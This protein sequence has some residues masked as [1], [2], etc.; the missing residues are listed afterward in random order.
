ML[1]KN[2]FHSYSIQ[3]IQSGLKKKKKVRLKEVDA[4]F[5]QLNM[6]R[7]SKSKQEE[8]F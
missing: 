8:K 2:V 7:G 6:G 5:I 1:Y 3:A 4:I